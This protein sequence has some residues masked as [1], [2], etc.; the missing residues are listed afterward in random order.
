[1]ASVEPRHAVASVA[2][3]PGARHPVTVG[4]PGKAILAQLP[5]HEWP[6]AVPSSLPAD[7]EATRSRG[8]ATSH[9]ESVI[10][11]VQSVARPPSPARPAPAAI[12]VVHVATDLDDAEIAARLQRSAS[13]I[14]ESLDG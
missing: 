2:Q 8:Y 12:A 5:E 11:T 7:V 3:R 10:P 4:A 1:M 6:E 14:R 9:D 13:V